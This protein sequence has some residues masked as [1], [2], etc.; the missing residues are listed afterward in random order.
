MPVGSSTSASPALFA[1]RNASAPGGQAII[2]VGIPVTSAAP[3]TQ[4]MTLSAPRSGPGTCRDRV[5]VEVVAL[6]C[7]LSG[8]LAGASFGGVGGAVGGSFAGRMVGLCVTAA[9][10][11]LCCSD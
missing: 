10:K 1:S 9:A 6:T 4:E 3:P 5:A 2:P 8:T 7:Q 11:D